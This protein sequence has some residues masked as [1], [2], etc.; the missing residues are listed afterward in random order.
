[1]QRERLKLHSP[2]KSLLSK[3]IDTS[4]VVE[5]IVQAQVCNISVPFFTLVGVLDTCSLLQIT[6]SKEEKLSEAKREI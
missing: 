2:Y 3:E 1:M 6:S 5:V 4:R